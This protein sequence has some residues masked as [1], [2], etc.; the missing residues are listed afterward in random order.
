[1]IS[2]RHATTTLLMALALAAGARPAAAQATKPAAADDTRDLN[3]RA[4]VELLRSDLRTEKVAII[5]EMMQFSEDEDTKFWPI[6]REYETQL[7]KLNDDRLAGIK[8]YALSYDKMTDDIADRLAHTA[9]DLEGRRHDL[10]A[11]F[12]EKFKSALSPK[13]AAR[14]LQVE[15]QLL[16]LLDLQIASSLPIIQ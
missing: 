7:S 14:F 3:L 16:L 6:Y 15:N 4:Y 5:T 8:Q 1:M 12:Y 11:Q 10:K 2:V 9:L 13:T